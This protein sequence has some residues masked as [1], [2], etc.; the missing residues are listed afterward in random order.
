LSGIAG[1][2]MASVFGLRVGDELGELAEFSHGGA[3]TQCSGRR[4]VGV[5]ERREGQ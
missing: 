1:D 4:S 2:I 5:S 3:A